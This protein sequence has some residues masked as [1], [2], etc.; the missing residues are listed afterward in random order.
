MEMVRL[1]LMDRSDFSP[2]HMYKTS[3]EG[4]SKSQVGN[5]IQ[6]SL[7]GVMD[8]CNAYVICLKY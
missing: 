6:C 1:A 3:E 2:E 4:R 7:S 5:G 8:I